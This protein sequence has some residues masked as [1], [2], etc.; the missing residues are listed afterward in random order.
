MQKFAQKVSFL[1]NIE[2]GVPN[3]QLKPTGPDQTV[4]TIFSGGGLC[5]D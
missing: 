5:E 1:E 4:Q 3:K 2:D